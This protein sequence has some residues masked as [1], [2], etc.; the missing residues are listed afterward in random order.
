MICTYKAPPRE[1]DSVA[2]V[3]APEPLKE[4][5]PLPRRR[6][7][8]TQRLAAPGGERSPRTGRPPLALPTSSPRLPGEAPCRG[9]A[10]E[11]PWRKAS[12]AE[13]VEHKCRQPLEQCDQTIKAQLRGQISVSGRIIARAIGHTTLVSSA[14]CMAEIKVWSSYCGVDCFTLTVIKNIRLS[15]ETVCFI[16]R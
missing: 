10:G 11:P 13:F 2:A 1:S 4:A 12:L 7:G 5:A 9:E 6:K 16:A 14:L 3:A 8:R 15:A